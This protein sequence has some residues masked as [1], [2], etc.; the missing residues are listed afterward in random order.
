MG[1]IDYSRI[2]SLLT[3]AKPPNQSCHYY[4]ATGMICYFFEYL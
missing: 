4:P 1:L 3:G 2:K